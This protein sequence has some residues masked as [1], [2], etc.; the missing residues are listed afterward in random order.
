MR[1]PLRRIVPLLVP[2]AALLLAGCGGGGGGSSS[3]APGRVEV[4]DNT[5]KPGALTV[6]VGDTVTWEF[7]GGAAHNVTFS[8]FRSENQSSGTYTHTFNT[9]GSFDYKCTI[10]AGMNGTIKVG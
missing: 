3:A 9:A 2:L 5:F 7:K 6:A 1:R 4:V 10:H 8:D